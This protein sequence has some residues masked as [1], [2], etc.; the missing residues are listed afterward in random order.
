M[1]EGFVEIGKSALNGVGDFKG[2]ARRLPS[3]DGFSDVL[4]DIDDRDPLI[5]RWSL[6]LKGLFDQLS[7]E[8]LNF[9]DVVVAVL[10]ADEGGGVDGEGVV[11]VDAAADAAV[12]LGPPDAFFEVGVGEGFVFSRLG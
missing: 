9:A 2:I 3:P 1:P 11:D 7:G 8:F 6:L 4:L 5:H 10:T 12:F